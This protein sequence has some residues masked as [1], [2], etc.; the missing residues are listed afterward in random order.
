MNIDDAGLTLADP[1][2]YAEEGRLHTALRVLREQDPVHRVD[3]RPDFNPF[4]AVTRHADLLEVERQNDTFINEPRPIL[5]KA[6]QDRHTAENGQALRTLVHIDDPEHKRMRAVVAD[7]FR[8]RALRALDVEVRRLAKRY[9]DKMADLGGECD[10]VREVTVDYPLYVILSLLGLP[11][12][13]FPRILQL[14]QE[15]FGIDDA[16]LQRGRSPEELMRVL[17]DFFDYFKQITADRRANP[18]GDL[19]STIANARIDGEHLSDLDTASHYV[20]I[21]TAGHDTTSSTISGGLH[22]LVEHPEEGERLRRDPELIPTAVEEMLR[23]V[24]PVKEFM[25]TATTDYEL[26]GKRI[27]AG[28]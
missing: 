12:S 11:E 16:E 28:E 22:A 25:R 4:W 14:T 2:A 23:W 3:P 1:D 17:L 26:G 27:A 6:E 7:W 8:P 10:F 24:T 13:D 9:V 19:A 5:V 20:I 18:T 21:A 15:L